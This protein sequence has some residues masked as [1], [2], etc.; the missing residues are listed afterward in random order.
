MCPGPPWRTKG[1]CWFHHEGL[2]PGQLK[3]AVDQYSASPL[4]VVGLNIDD[5]VAGAQ[6]MAE[7]QG[8]DWAQNYLGSDSDLMRELAMS[9]VPTYYLI[10][11]DGKLVGSA[12]EWEEM[13]KLLG[14]ALR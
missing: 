14:E 1:L 6:A 13:E 2:E 3:S 4:K 7:S 10:G 9:S 8:W 12:I 5:D 11:P